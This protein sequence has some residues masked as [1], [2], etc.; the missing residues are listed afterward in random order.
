MR[1]DCQDG[2]EVRSFEVSDELAGVAIR[3]FKGDYNSYRK[4]ERKLYEQN[5][6]GEFKLIHM[7]DSEVSESFEQDPAVIY[8]KKE[9]HNELEA[10][11]KQLPS[12]YLDLIIAVF[13]NDVTLTEYAKQIGRDKALVSR[14]LKKALLLAKK[15]L[16]KT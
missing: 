3:L 12:A 11:L 8:E 2:Q 7:P 16:T 4:D 9:Q 1:V 6:R 15:I 10:M 13:F 14:R 5:K